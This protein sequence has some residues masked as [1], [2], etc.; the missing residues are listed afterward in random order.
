MESERSSLF[1][2]L[3]TLLS[4]GVVAGFLRNALAD[5]PQLETT[6][7]EVACGDRG[8]T[9]ALR[10]RAS[11]RSALGRTWWFQLDQEPVAVRCERQYLV[12][13]DYAC[14]LSSSTPPAVLNDTR[15]TAPAPNRPAP[16]SS[17]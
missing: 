5:E 14:K 12:L 8:A 3:L 2:T 15:T 16:K 9:C 1:S 7:H 13:G 10:V 6:V 4:M 11:E 17:R